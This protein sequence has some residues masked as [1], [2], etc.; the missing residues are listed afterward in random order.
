MGIGRDV[1]PRV[2]VMNNSFV[3]DVNPL[4]AIDFF[5]GRIC[6]NVFYCIQVFTCF[7]LPEDD[8]TVVAS[9]CSNF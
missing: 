3:S 5:C 4:A 6:V 2:A 9:K 7:D 1:N 8:S